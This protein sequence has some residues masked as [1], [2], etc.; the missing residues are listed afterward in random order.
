MP[1]LKPKIGKDYLANSGLPVR[2]AENGNGY[3]V[4]QS[5]ASDNLFVVPVDYPLQFFNNKKL[6]CKLRENPYSERT[7]RKGNGGQAKPKSLAPI[8]D[9]LLL[10]G[11]RTM[12]G[13]VREVKRRASSACKGKD[14]RSNTRA[15]IYWLKR[16][17][18][19]AKRNG[20]GRIKVF[21]VITV[22]LL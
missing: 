8:I 15:R 18:Y 17:G 14:V 12:R 2:V 19:T 16:K 7:E 11:G 21:P 13:L 22:E 1:A 3:L 10:E 9:A 4:L 5:L 6:T 20:Q